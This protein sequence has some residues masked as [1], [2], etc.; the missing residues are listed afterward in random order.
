VFSDRAFGSESKSNKSKS[1]GRDYSRHVMIAALSSDIWWWYYTLHFDMY[2][3]K[4]YM[5]FGFPFDF[6]TCAQRTALGRLGKQLVD[7]LF[8]NAERKVQT[9]ASTGERAQLIFRPALSKP[10]IDRIDRLLAVHYRFTE[11]ELDFIIN[12]DI[13]YRMGHDGA[14][15]EEDDAAAAD[16]AHPVGEKLLKVAEPRHPYGDRQKDG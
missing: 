5:M 8:K 16:R 3:C 14:E 15:G 10:I 6:T 4:D 12:Y 1:F 7:D 13:K 9:Y 2:N 11:G